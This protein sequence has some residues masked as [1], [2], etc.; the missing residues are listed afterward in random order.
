MTH[1][2]Q[3]NR[4]RSIKHRATSLIAASALSLTLTPSIAL[5]EGASDAQA[6][7]PAQAFEANESGSASE[8]QS[9]DQTDASEA[10][11]EGIAADA[12]HAQDPEPS[13]SEQRLSDEP[14][15]LSM[16]VARIAGGAE[17]ATFDEAVAAAPDGSTIELLADATTTGLNLRKNLTIDGGSA[18]HSLAFADKG[19]CPAG[20]E[21]DA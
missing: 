2:N 11:E 12:N 10:P 18:K 5:A 20:Q 19:S 21:P 17:F 1:V 7:Q 6:Q 3:E 15:P 13:T 9:I 8:N 4:T 16:P 14:T